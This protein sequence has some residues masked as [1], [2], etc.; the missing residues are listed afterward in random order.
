MALPSP[1]PCPVFLSMF[2]CPLLPKSAGGGAARG[3]ILAVRMVSG[4]GFGLD[5]ISTLTYELGYLPSYFWLSVLLAVKWGLFL[6]L[7]CTLLRVVGKLL[8]NKDVKTVC[9]L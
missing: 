5:C 1:P 9:K 6:Y 3:N 2:L 8:R 4:L 7:P